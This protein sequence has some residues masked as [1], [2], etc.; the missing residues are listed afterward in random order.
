MLAEMKD[1]FERNLK[2]D[3]KQ[4]LDSHC[5]PCPLSAPDLRNCT[6]VGLRAVS[7]SRVIS[8]AGS[9]HAASGRARSRESRQKQELESM[10]AF[11]KLR[12]SKLAEIQAAT[13]SKDEKEATLAD[14]MEK[15]AQAEEDLDTTKDEKQRRGP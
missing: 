14:T 3:Q 5:P 6:L 12:S 10:I 7:S 4:E 11:Q 2:A 9:A 13:T 1:E 15:K 8:A